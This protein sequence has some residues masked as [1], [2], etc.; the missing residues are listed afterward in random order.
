MTLA[1]D[2]RVEMVLGCAEAN[3][4][5]SAE[6]VAGE[7]GSFMI[8][9]LDLNPAK[10]SDSSLQSQI[11]QDMNQVNSYLKRDGQLDLKLTGGEGTYVWEPDDEQ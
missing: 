4:P 2:G 6:P 9:P 5:W 7:A 3:G 10:C 11:V 8:G 1:D